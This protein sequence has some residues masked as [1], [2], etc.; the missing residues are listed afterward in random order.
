MRTNQAVADAVAATGAC[1]CCCCGCFS[2]SAADTLPWA[3]AGALRA[4]LAAF[5]GGGG[6]LLP[7]KNPLTWG[8][9][10]AAAGAAGAPLVDAGPEAPL[11]ETGAALAAAGAG[12]ALAAAGAGAALVGAGALVALLP[13]GPGAATLLPACWFHRSCSCA[14]RARTLSSCDL[15]GGGA[16]AIV[17]VAQQR[18]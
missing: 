8:S 10:A 9:A 3:G 12:T 14:W 4:W 2:P 13:A 5:L 17:P 7:A 6:L 11:F 1:C 16:T 15:Q 18:L